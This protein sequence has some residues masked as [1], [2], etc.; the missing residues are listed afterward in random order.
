MLSVA[1]RNLKDIDIISSEFK[2]NPFDFYARLRSESPI[3]ETTMSGK[4]P[5][6]LVTRYDDVKAVM[7]DERFVKDQNNVQGKT[8]LEMAWMPGFLQ[9]LRSNMLDSDVPDHTRLKNLVHKAFT[10]RRIQEMQKR[11]AELSD[12]YLAAGKKKGEFD[13]IAEYALPIPATVIAEILGIPTDDIGKFHRWSNN[14]LQADF[15]SPISM[16]KML[17]GVWQFVRYIRKQ[18]QQRRQAPQDDLL[19]ALVEAEDN[20]D[21][22]S[23]D[24]AIAMVVLLLIAGHET[25]VNLI[26]NGTLALLQHPEQLA[27]LQNDPS[28]IGSAIEEVLRYTVPIETATERYAR[29]DITLRG[30][31]IPQGSLMLAAIASANRDDAVFDNPNRLDITRTPNKHLSFGHGIHYCLGAPLARMEGAIALGTLF[32]TTPTLQL[33]VPANELVWRNGMIL[34]GLKH[35]P[36]RV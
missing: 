14:F 5:V 8:P 1:E 26:G 3:F 11:I 36:V 20:G 2:A 7:M 31:T 4:I 13:L 19:T 25:T 30:Q 15:G 28:L 12:M 33:A 9:A 17:P 24:E 10:P 27:L 6:W 34:R 21:S 32:E 23:E 16:I 29:E 35:L 22:L 18:L